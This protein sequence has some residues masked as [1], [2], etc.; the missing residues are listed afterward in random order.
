MGRALGWN[1]PGEDGD[2]TVTSFRRDTKAL[3]LA[4]GSQENE[5]NALNPTSDCSYDQDTK[6]AGDCPAPLRNGTGKFAQVPD[7]PQQ[8]PSE[9]TLMLL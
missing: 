8:R 2:A 1:A 4:Q 9:A 7:R 3:D 5:A 6:Q